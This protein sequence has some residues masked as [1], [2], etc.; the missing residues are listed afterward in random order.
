MAELQVLCHIIEA[1][2]YWVAGTE[3]NIKLAPAP[4]AHAGNR[5]ERIGE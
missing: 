3:V 2:T 1:A 4:E 5:K